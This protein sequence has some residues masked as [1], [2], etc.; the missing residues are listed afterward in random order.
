MKHAWVIFSVMGIVWLFGT[1]ISLYSEHHGMNFSEGKEARFTKTES[2]LWATST[3]A[4]SNGSVNS[5]HSSLSP[6]SGG[7]ALF[8]MMLGEIIFGG[9]GSGMYGMII[10][11]LLTIFLSGLMVGRTPEYLNKKINADDIKFVLIALIAPSCTILLGSVLSLLTD[12]GLS[13]RLSSGPHGFS[14]IL[15]AWSS[16][17]GN[18]GS[19]FAG[20]NA[21]T[22][23]YNVLLGLAMLIGRFGVIIPCFY[24]AHSFATKKMIQGNSGQMSTESIIFAVLLLSIIIIVG[25]LTFFP[26]LLL[27]PIVEHLIMNQ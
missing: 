7:V 14:E 23:F 27:G 19:A 17:A 4:A 6:L 20:L 3:T 10:F 2:I 8:N 16:A 22:I 9:V 15:Y 26:T 11:I 1:S 13:S 18:N 21:N 12:A 25:A 24:L 5:M